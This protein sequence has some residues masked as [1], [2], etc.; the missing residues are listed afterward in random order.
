MFSYH[1]N[2]TA[3]HPFQSPWF[4]W[5]FVIR[6]IYFFAG[7][8]LPEGTMQA[9]ASFGN[10]IVWWAGF[11]SL[12]AVAAVMATR[13]ADKQQRSAYAFVLICLGAAFLPWTLITR[14]T[15]IYHYFASVPFIILL[16]ASLVLYTKK[17]SLPIWAWALCI[18][19]AAVFALFYPVLSGLPISRAIALKW[20]KWLPTWWFFS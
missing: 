17:R 5:P 1:S 20:M 6:P 16:T 11:L 19:S 10:P 13:R 18:V 14:A 8:G 2:L 9:I 3:T 7:E 15:F 4:S 12:I